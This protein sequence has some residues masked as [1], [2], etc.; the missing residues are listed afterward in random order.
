MTRE[1]MMNSLAIDL[2]GTINVFGRR[3]DIIIRYYD[4]TEENL[5]KFS[6]WSRQYH[7]LFPGLEYLLVFETEKPIT[8]LPND[9]KPD[10]TSLLYAVNVSGDSCLTAAAELL[11]LASRKGL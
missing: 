9:Y 1:Q 3:D 5:A 11:D 10:T 6:P 8:E 7:S 4:M 2:T